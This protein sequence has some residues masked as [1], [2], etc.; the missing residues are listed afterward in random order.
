MIAIIPARGGSKG[1]PG[2]NIKLLNGIPLIAYTI[3][4]ALKAA[5]I[6]RVIVSTDDEEIANISKKY[7]AEVPF[8][9]PK[10]LSTDMATSIDVYKY[11]INKLEQEEGITINTF[12]ILQPTSPLRECKQI[13]AAITLF[14]EKNG[15]SVISYCEEH[16]PIFWH[17]KIKDDATFENIFDDDYILNRQQIEKTFYPNGAIYVLKKKLLRMETYYT[18]NSYGY[19]MNRNQSVDIDTLDDFE[20]AQFLINK[21]SN[22]KN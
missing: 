20:Y 2:K 15:D 17:K 6:S 10:E 1:L 21:E 22:D 3:K 11:T 4:A 7:G 16:H 8:M 19:I 5:L 14:N 18:A 9:R 12:T 13:D